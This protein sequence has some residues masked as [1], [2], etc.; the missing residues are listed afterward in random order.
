MGEKMKEL[1]NWLKTTAIEIRIMKST[2]R[3]CQRHGRHSEIHKLQLGIDRLRLR[4]RHKHI[5]YSELRGKTRAQIENPREN[6]Y[7]DESLIQQYK[8]AYKEEPQTLCISA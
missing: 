6:N 2:L 3:D 5:A 4:Y 7:P 1:K 8:D